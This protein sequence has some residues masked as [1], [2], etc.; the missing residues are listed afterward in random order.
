MIQDPFEVLGLPQ[1]AGEQAIRQRYL[2]LV[3]KHSPER[4]PATFA[5]VRAAYDQI[6]DP[7]ASLQHRLFCDHWSVSWEELLRRLRDTAAQQRIP[8]ELLLSLKG[9]L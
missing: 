9:D 5:R 7:V 8:T 3:R 1:D 6:R 2:E 4:D